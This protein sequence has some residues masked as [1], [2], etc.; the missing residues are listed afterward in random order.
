MDVAR[1]HLTGEP[2]DHRV[3]RDGDRDL[4]FRGWLLG[5][6]EHG[7]GGDYPSDWTRGV[8]VSIYLTTGGNWVTA[9]RSWSSWQGES[10][11]HDAAV[12]DTPNAALAWLIEDAGGVLGPASKQAW[13]SACDSYPPLRDHETER[14]E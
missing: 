5:E 7:S 4:S 1:E 11:S 9:R 2:T 8:D 13:E 6:S 14:V 12:H 10:D 3:K